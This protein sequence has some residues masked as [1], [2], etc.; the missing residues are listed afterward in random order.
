MSGEGASPPP[1]TVRSAFEPGVTVAIACYDQA[2]FLA[3]A[4]ES[5]LAQTRPADA[6]IL[7]DD[8]SRDATAEVAARYPQVRYHRQDNAGLSAARNTGLRLART[9]HILFLDADDLL[10]PGALAAAT[11]RLAERPG[12]AFVYGGYR[13]VSETRVPLYEWSVVEPEDAYAALLHDNYIGMHGT[14]LY[15]AARLRA[16]GGFDSAL[17]SCEDWD[18]YLRLSRGHPIAAYPAIAAEYRRHGASMSV[19]VPRMI[20]NTR[21]VLDRQRALGLNQQQA[22]AARAGLA[23]ARRF[24]SLRLIGE[25][26]AD[27]SRAAPILRA[28]FGN[29]P[30]F[31]FRLLAAL[32]RLVFPRAR[33][34]PPRRRVS[35]R[36]SPGP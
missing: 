36:A 7:V 8:G 24:L 30:W 6:I 21:R 23:F 32:P 14:V 35:R 29:D 22:R 26:K 2:H 34:A 25:L 16:A 1:A 4:I 12:A 13:E 19:N 27:P 5:V 20:A 3:D 15:D 11:A 18:V 10:L 9:S 17:T 31:G 33:R 28:G